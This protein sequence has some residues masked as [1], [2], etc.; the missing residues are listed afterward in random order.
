[1]RT[2]GLR[3][4][5]DSVLACRRQQGH[6]GWIS[7]TTDAAGDGAAGGGASDGGSG[8]GT[9]PVFRPSD[10]ELSFL[11]GLDDIESGAWS[12][13]GSNGGGG[14][15]SHGAGTGSTTRT[16]RSWHR[17]RPRTHSGEA[18]LLACSGEAVYG[19]GGDI[20]QHN[21]SFQIGSGKAR[22]YLRLLQ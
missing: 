15:D 9:H 12:G 8:G 13:M 20:A 6:G 4:V 21:S 11:P 7:P 5:H 3:L 2:G 18:A 10:R 19:G 17:H 1:M 14:G 22:A 16:D